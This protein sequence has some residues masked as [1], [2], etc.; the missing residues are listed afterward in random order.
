MILR[1][2]YSQ[3]PN[4]KKNNNKAIFL[5]QKSHKNSIKLCSNKILLIPMSNSNRIAN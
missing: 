5:T 3:N 2:G 1:D 4:S